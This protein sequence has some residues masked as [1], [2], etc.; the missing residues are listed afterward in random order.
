MSAL[1]N[2]YISI[3]VVVIA[4]VAAQFPALGQWIAD[5]TKAHTHLV[6]IIEGV[7]GIALLF[8][9]TQTTKPVAGVKP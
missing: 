7:I 9:A 3:I 8:F 1:N 6:T 5:E 4:T 2:K